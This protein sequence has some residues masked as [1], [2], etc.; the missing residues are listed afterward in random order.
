MSDELTPATEALDR[1]EQALRKLD[2]GCCDPGRSPSMIS[3][4]VTLGEARNA[5]ETVDGRPEGAQA[6]IERLEDAG[7]QIGRLQV[8]CCTPKR[9]RLYAE[10]L[11]G[12]TAAQIAVSRSVGQG[13]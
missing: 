5:V 13:H 11:D 8:T 1:C 3:L 6:A 10:F 12:L 4:G 7:A 9:M 2:L